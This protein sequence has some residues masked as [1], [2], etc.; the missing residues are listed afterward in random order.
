MLLWRLD[1]VARAFAKSMDWSGICAVLAEKPISI[2][3]P[4]INILCLGKGTKGEGAFVGVCRT[5]ECRG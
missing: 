4:Y 2:A 1:S 3:L 5:N